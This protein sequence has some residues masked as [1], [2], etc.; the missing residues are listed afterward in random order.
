MPVFFVEELVVPSNCVVPTNCVVVGSLVDE[1]NETSGRSGDAVGDVPQESDG[2]WIAHRHTNLSWLL[3]SQGRRG[4]QDPESRAQQ[5][6][7]VIQHEPIIGGF[8]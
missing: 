4:A 1:E 6:P 2:R 3:R 8:I 5:Q 7:S